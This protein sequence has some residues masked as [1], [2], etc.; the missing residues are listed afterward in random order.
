MKYWNSFLTWI[1]ESILLID[2]TAAE[3]RRRHPEDAARGSYDYLDEDPIIDPRALVQSQ[4]ARDSLVGR[5]HPSF[6]TLPPAF[7]V[8]PAPRPAP[9]DDLPSFKPLPSAVAPVAVAAVDTPSVKPVEAALKAHDA[10]RAAGE[11]PEAALKAAKEAAAKAR[12]NAPRSAAK[13]RPAKPAPKDGGKPKATP[14]PKKAASPVHISKG[15]TNSEVSQVKQRPAA[16]K[17][18]KPSRRS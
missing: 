16:P 1:R 4:L 9:P 2:T 11:E 6:P 14:A 10:A 3:Q 8:P 5:A 12:A 17:P 7:A 13:A 18:T 15:G